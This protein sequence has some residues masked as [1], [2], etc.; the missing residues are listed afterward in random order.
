MAILR[1]DAR[2]LLAQ[3]AEM[4]VTPLVVAHGHPPDQAGRRR[5]APEAGALRP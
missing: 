2:H 5:A 3:P 1:S 4:E